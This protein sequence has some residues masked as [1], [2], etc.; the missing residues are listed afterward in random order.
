MNFY[1][2]LFLVTILNLERYRYNYGR[3]ASQTRLKTISIK[4]PVRNGQPD[5]EFMMQCI[6]G[7]PYSKLLMYIKHIEKN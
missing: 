3:K 1:V 5:F 2:D 4:L 6:K 7:L